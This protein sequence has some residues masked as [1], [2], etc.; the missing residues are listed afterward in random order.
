MR[1]DAATYYVAVSGGSD[2]RSCATAQTLATPKRTIS[3]AVMCLS[4]G[5]TLYV[6]SGEY[7]E[8]LST[9]PQGSS[10]NYIHIVAYPSETVLV[11]PTGSPEA[12][13]LMYHGAP[14]YIEFDGINLDGEFTTNSTV[15]I[16]G[17]G[18]GSE[19]EIHHIRMKNAE[20]Q[21]A[22]IAVDT[23]N[24]STGQLGVY[25]FQNLNVH[26]CG[27]TYF[28]HCF[29]IKSNNTVIENSNIWDFGGGGIHFYSNPDFDTTTM[30]GNIARNNSI[31]DNRPGAHQSWGIIDANNDDNV[32]I[33]NNVIYG[34][35]D[36]G[37][38]NVDGIALFAGTAAHVWNNTIVGSPYY[39]IK[40]YSGVPDS[41]IRNNIV[42][43]AVGQ[44]Y[45]NLGTG[46]SC[47]YMVSDD[48]LSGCS[49][50]SSNTNPSFLDAG[51]H[52]YHLID[53]SAG[54]D[55]GTTLSDV[56]TDKDGLSRPAGSAYDIGAYEFDGEDVPAITPVDHATGTIIVTESFTDSAGTALESHV[57]E[58]GATWAKQTGSSGS[59]VIS[60]ANRARANSA[61][62]STRYYA[63]GVPTTANYD[64]IA[65]LRFLSLVPGHFCAVWGRMDPS[66][67]FTG[68]Y[69]Q[70]NVSD[71]RWDLNVGSSGS[72]TALAAVSA[73]PTLNVTYQV[74]LQ[75]RGTQIT[76]ELD[77]VPILQV[78]D[79]T[80]TAAGR[81]GL[82]LFSA[83]PAPT[84]STGCHID[85]IQLRQT[86]DAPGQPTLSRLRFTLGQ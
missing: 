62:A 14:R 27:D 54:I 23:V 79:A 40:V 64:V 21:S 77:D 28:L 75:F 85:N 42:V 76:M 24:N 59:V 43:G 10:G 9:F 73:T 3:S 5:D 29:Y 31:H 81:A 46:S 48:T 45:L 36:D 68:Y 80:N 60:N 50:S 4:P 51:T 11:K 13:V 49:N 61:D 1:A 18:A 6:R 47:A 35:T 74:R 58:V 65:D 55:V 72:S 20:I 57:G 32:Q 53:G 30:H 86:V 41:E 12:V 52:N 15:E 26:R 8:V 25:E 69:A 7:D 2:A 19:G 37:S 22:G 56:T 44:S 34:M 38:G 78:T 82:N 66:V 17:Y 70:Y 63:S 83:S 84:N 67:S 33:Y 16:V 71:S 39:G